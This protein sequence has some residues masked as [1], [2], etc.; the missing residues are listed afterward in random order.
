LS[1]FNQTEIRLTDLKKKNSHISHFVT[2]C[3][4]GADMFH[5]GRQADRRTWQN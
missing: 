3:L 1:D 2:V 4:V 5:A